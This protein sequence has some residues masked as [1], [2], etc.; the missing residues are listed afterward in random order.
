MIDL[1]L[2]KRDMLRYIQDV[3]V[4]RGMRRGLSDHH[5]VPCKVRLI[6]AW[7]KRRGV[8]VWGRGIKSEKLR[9]HQYREGYTRFCG[10]GSRME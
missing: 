9:E 6:G 10:E 2:L 1:L 8:E 5:V 4:V 7:I 3:R